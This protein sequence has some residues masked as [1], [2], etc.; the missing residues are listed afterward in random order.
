MRES[1]KT[2]AGSRAVPL[3]TTSWT[4]GAIRSAKVDPADRAVNRTVVSE[5]KVPPWGA[6]VRSSVIS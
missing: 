2:S 5:R 4:A 1:A 3:S 6:P